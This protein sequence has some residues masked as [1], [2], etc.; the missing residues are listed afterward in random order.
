MS[1]KHLHGTIVSGQ[2][3]LKRAG[4]GPTRLASDG[5]GVQSARPPSHLPRRPPTVGTDLRNPAPCDSAGDASSVRLTFTVNRPWTD[6]EPRSPHHSQLI[7]SQT[8][9]RLLIDNILLP[10]PPK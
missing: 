1:L 9:L 7:R 10:P 5:Q 6:L 4:P 2:D 3:A 8:I